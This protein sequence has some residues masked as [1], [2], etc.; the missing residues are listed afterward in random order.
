[1]FTF[2]NQ[3]VR[4]RSITHI[5]IWEDFF[6]STNIVQTRRSSWTNCYRT[7]GIFHVRGFL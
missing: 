4:V 5:Y 1:V 6:K 7:L 3:K 2:T